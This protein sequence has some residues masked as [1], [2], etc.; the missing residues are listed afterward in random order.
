MSK[1]SNLLGG[2]RSLASHL[3]RLRLVLDNLGARLRDGVARAVGQ[4]V[5]AAVH[6]AMHDLLGVGDDDSEPDPYRDTWYEP[7]PRDHRWGHDST[8]RDPDPYDDEYEAQ[9]SPPEKTSSRLGRWGQALV[10]L[11]QA[12]TWWLRPRRLRYPVLAAV[13]IGLASALA[14]YAGG[15]FVLAGVGGSA[16]SLACLA[17]SVHDG[18][19][20][21]LAL[22]RHLCVGASANPRK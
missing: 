18:A 15:P 3:D 20:A 16:L 22:R 13:G 1:W 5:A 12:G 6:E 2:G 19:A 11:S 4:T 9:T 14:I 7:N 8:D 21:L 17:E 10:L